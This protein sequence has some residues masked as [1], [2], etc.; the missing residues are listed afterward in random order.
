MDFKQSEGKVILEYNDHGYIVEYKLEG[1]FTE[2]QYKF[3]FDRFPFTS[4]RLEEWKKL[5]SGRISVNEIEP[6]LSFQRFWDE[7]DNKIGA[8]ARVQK[9]WELLPDSDKISA[10]KYI[11][12]YDMVLLKNQGT[13]KAYPET[14]L[15]QRRWEV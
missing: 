9:K 7:Y 14:Y 4:H 3:F 6:D 15:N 5:G 11:A 8:R 2:D 13:S 12:I 1:S 10:L